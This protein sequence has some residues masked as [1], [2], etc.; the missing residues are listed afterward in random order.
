MIQVIFLEKTHIIYFNKIISEMKVCGFS[1][2]KNAIK[3][4]YP[5]VEAIQSILPICDHMVVAVGKSEDATLELIRGINSKKI[6]IIETIW[7]ESLRE[8]GA[9]LAEETGFIVHRH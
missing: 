9:V 8:G 1:F 4:D 5:I 7:D 3:Y 2:V 6:E